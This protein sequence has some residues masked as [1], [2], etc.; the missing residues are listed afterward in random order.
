MKICILNTLKKNIINTSLYETGD[1]LLL[2]NN[3]ALINIKERGSDIIN[4]S[5]ELYNCS[6]PKN[7]EINISKIINEQTLTEAILSIIKSFKSVDLKLNLVNNE[8][9]YAF[10]EVCYYGR[11]DEQYI[12]DYF[13][14]FLP[15]IEGQIFETFTVCNTIPH[16]TVGYITNTTKIIKKN[17]I[18][19][20][21]I[22]GMDDIFNEINKYFNISKSD[23]KD[24]GAINIPGILLYGPPGTGKTSLV[25]YIASINNFNLI[26]ISPAIVLNK[27]LGG[28]EEKLRKLFKNAK[29][30]LP[31]IIF[32]D[33]IDS[34]VGKSKNNKYISDTVI[35][36]LLEL[37]DDAEKIPDLY[38]FAATNNKNL[39]DKRVI[40]PGRIGKHI[41]VGP[42]THDGIVNIFKK[43]TSSMNIA[44]DVNFDELAKRVEGKSGAYIKEICTDVGFNTLKKPKIDDHYVVT[45]DTFIEVI[46]TMVK[47]KSSIIEDKIS[48]DMI[49]GMDKEILELRKILETPDN[50]YKKLGTNRITGVILYGPPGTGK[51]LIAKSIASQ[52][53]YSF[54][55]INCSDIIS[56]YNGGTEQKLREIFDNAKNSSPA[57]IFM[58]EIDTLC[59]S[60]E[61]NINSTLTQLLTLMNDNIKDIFYIGATNKLNNLDSAIRR[62]GRF[63]REIYIGP[64]DKQGLVSLLKLYTKDMQ[65]ENN[66]DYES[67]ANVINGYTGADVKQLCSQ[68]G[69]N[70]LI[71]YDIKTIEEIDIKFKINDFLNIIKNFKPSTMKDYNE[72]NSNVNWDDIIGLE[73][74]KRKISEIFDTN[75]NEYL[76][77]KKISLPKGIILYGP[78]GNGK[79][80]LAKAAANHY[81][82][83]FY[84]RSASEFISKYVGESEKNIRDLFQLARSTKPSIIFLDEFDSI[85]S[86]RDNLLHIHNNNVVNQLLTELDGINSND[87]VFILAATNNIDKIDPAVI[88]PGRFD[89][90][91]MISNPDAKTRKIMLT[92]HIDFQNSDE[93]NSAVE[94]TKDYSAAEITAHIEQSYKDMYYIDKESNPTYKVFCDTFK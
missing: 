73:Y 40:R 42:P 68:V 53:H 47:D 7:K 55:I 71:N 41:Y 31:C 85:A 17:K 28:T 4:V 35:T 8:D 34:L 26:Y 19:N 38:I 67:I 78:P 37:I 24:V 63:G 65:L 89:N 87:G 51:T 15:M 50:V 16:N 79:T 2:N 20:D 84:A 36:Q 29:N 75:K 21:D 18:N 22:I 32:L 44:D 70:Y 60:R 27:Y 25:K 11:V 33:E 59:K 10:T 92:K 66:F 30:Q 94:L 88:R 6:I 56:P 39:I 3:T 9:I 82:M 5:K 91:I 80:L 1:I 54:H 83:N 64:P 77:S 13:N 12:R 46:N 72:I 93:I 49:A 14:P 58:D 69:L 23:L 62:S 57:I 76:K 86:N 74:A 52:L 45:M 48:Y 43:Y 90:K 81:K 61:N